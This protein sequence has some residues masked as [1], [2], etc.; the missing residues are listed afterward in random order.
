MT[1]AGWYP[2]PNGTA[3]QRWWDGQ[4]RRSPSMRRRNRR[5]RTRSRGLCLARARHGMNECHGTM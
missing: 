4:R 2:D 3:Q 1:N 5:S